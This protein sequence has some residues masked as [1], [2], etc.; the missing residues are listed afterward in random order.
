MWNK[1]NNSDM[2]IHGRELS[3]KGPFVEDQIR[4]NGFTLTIRKYTSDSTCQILGY[5]S[6]FKLQ[7]GDVVYFLDGKVH[8]INGPAVICQGVLFIWAKNGKVH[9]DDLPAVET[10]DDSLQIYYEDGFKHRVNGP[11]VISGNTK[12]YWIYNRQFIDED[13]YVNESRGTILD[14]IFEE[15]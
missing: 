5:D 4:E 1:S 6:N 2:V 15:D 8:R 9:R 12:E 11:A 7:G 13:E 14:F 3:K 10:Q